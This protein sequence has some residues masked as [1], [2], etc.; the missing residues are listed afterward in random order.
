MA[1]AAPAVKPW[2]EEERKLLWNLVKQGE[3]DINSDADT[4]YINK[5]QF[6][7]FCKGDNRNFCRNFRAKHKH[8][9]SKT[10]L[11]APANGKKEV[12]ID[13][14]F[15]NYLCITHAHPFPPSMNAQR[16]K[17]AMQVRL[18]Q[19]RTVRVGW[20]QQK[21]TKLDVA[22]LVKTSNTVVFLW[23]VAWAI[24]ST[25]HTVLIASPGAAIFG[26]DMLF[27]ILF[28]A[29]SKKNGEHRQRLPDLNTA[30][31]N[32]GR[33]DYDYKVG[34]NILVR[35]DGILRQ[36]ESRYQKEPWSSTSVKSNGT[37]T[38]QY[39][40]KLERMNIWRVKLF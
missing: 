35:N 27:D 21:T 4:A 37:I 14:Y 5:G 32:K 20:Q 15:F 30:R 28:V 1:N 18:T 8:K 22:E 39:G 2:G 7:Y 40:N 33:I 26:R 16:E 9:S 29:D 19:A 17:R 36:A 31:E 12:R 38:V 23:D 11:A 34:Q 3:V 25:Y 24:H 10:P 13:V 6:D